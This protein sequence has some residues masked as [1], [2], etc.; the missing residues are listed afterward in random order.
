[1]IGLVFIRKCAIIECDL[2]KFMC[3]KIYLCSVALFICSLQSALCN[4][5]EIK[6]K[7][8]NDAMAERAMLMVEAHKLEEKLNKA[9]ADKNYTSAEIERLRERYQQLNF[10][11][12]EVREKLK[13]EVKKL[14]EVKKQEQQVEKMRIK[15]QSAEKKIE[16][17]RK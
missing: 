9:W 13:G 3:M 17:L 8:L 6:K 5:V 1:M 7:Q 2:R 11:M 12:I 14:P 15:Q 16:E 10:E 4:G